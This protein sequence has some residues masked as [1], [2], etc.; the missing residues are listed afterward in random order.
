[1][2]MQGIHYY[3]N[4]YG[5]FNEDKRS[6]NYIPDTMV[7]RVIV[8]FIIY[9]LVR[10]GGGL[11]LDGYNLNESPSL[12]HTTSWPFIVKIGRWLIALDFFFYCYHRAC[13][14]VRFLWKIHSLH[15]SSK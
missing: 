2:L 8:A 10:T 5:T 3:M 4:Y 13:H 12:G 11:T 14:T 1:M 6:R 7:K 9:M 15:H